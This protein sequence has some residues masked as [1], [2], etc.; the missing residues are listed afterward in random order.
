MQPQYGPSQY[1][2]LLRRM[3]LKQNPWTLKSELDDDKQKD[4]E[5]Y[6]GG[7]GT[8]ITEVHAPTYFCIRLSPGAKVIEEPRNESHGLFFFSIFYE[9]IV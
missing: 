9:H 2:I 4:V 5:I 1:W 3:G 6:V 8:E 7:L